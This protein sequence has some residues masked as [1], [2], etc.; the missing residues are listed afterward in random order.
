MPI[1]KFFVNPL[2]R[3]R[4]PNT[5]GDW[6]T[7]YE[8]QSVREYQARDGTRYFEPCTGSED[9]LEDHPSGQAVG[10]PLVGLYGRLNTGGVDHIADYDTLKEAEKTLAR[11][12]V[13]THH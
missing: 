10:Q 4:D 6:F 5:P 11:M 1:Y 2:T 3:D 7:H 13:V 8:I 9:M 12:G